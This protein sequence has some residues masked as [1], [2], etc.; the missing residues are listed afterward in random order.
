MDEV[1]RLIKELEKPGTDG[2]RILFPDMTEEEINRRIYEV[3]K[4]YLKDE[5]D[6]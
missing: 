2:L 5:D 1:D 6:E 3:V 4:K